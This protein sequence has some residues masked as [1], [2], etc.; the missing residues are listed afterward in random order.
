MEESISCQCG[1]PLL[2]SVEGKTTRFYVYRPLPPSLIMAS[3]YPRAA[4]SGMLSSQGTR[5]LTRCPKCT[6]ALDI[7][8]TVQ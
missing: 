1:Y 5:T 4:A 7:G 3:A 2:R 8:T 6:V